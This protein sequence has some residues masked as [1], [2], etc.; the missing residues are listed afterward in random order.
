[1]AEI[2]VT[3]SELR[4]KAD[5]LQQYLTKFRN[6]VTNMVGYEQELAGMFEGESQAAFHKAFTDDK[7]KMDLFA[8][9]IERYIAALRADADKYDQAESMATQIATSRNS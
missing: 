8:Q 1:M 5:S 9:N 4:N 2:R 3:S 7:T 6:E